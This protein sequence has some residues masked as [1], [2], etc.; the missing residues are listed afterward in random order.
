MLRRSFQ[1]DPV[2]KG[3]KSIIDTKWRE[4]KAPEHVGGEASRRQGKT[5]RKWLPILP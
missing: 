4:G 2:G 1:T 3:S 5:E